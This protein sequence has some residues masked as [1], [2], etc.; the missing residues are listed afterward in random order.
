VRVGGIEVAEQFTGF[1]R[2]AIEFLDGL[3]KNNSREVW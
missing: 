1:P 2:E 3:E